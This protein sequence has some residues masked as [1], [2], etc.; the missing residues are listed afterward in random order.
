VTSNNCATSY[1]PAAECGSGFQVVD[2]VKLGTSG[3][4]NLLWKGSTSQN[5]VITLKMASVG[6]P[7]ATSAF[8]EPQGSSRTTDSGSFSYYAGPVI[9]TAPTCVKW[10]GSAG[11]NTYTSGFEHC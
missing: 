2:S 10:G 8:L 1:D 11:G 4:V 5:C 3:T 7:T 9:R 6:T